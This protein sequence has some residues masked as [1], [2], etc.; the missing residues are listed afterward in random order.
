MLWGAVLPLLLPRLPLVGWLAQQR[1]VASFG[2]A[3]AF[4]KGW[5]AE[6]ELVTVFALLIYLLLV[7]W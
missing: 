3:D 7:A 5:Q 2:V 4:F 1:L 6:R